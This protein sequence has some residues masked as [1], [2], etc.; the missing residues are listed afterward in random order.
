MHMV[1]L[2]LPG[3]PAAKNR[4]FGD[5]RLVVVSNR[6]PFPSSAAEP[7]AGGLAVAMDAVIAYVRGL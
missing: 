3:K 4:S 7:A 5:G 1:Y 6:V 2:E